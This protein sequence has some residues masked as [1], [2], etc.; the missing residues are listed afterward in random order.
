MASTSPRFGVGP[1]QDQTGRVIKFDFKTPAYGA[2]IAVHPNAS[3][4]IVKVAQLTGAATITASTVDAYAGDELIFLFAADGTGR[5]VTFG[6]GLKP[7]A[8]L[9]VTA[10]KFGSASFMFDGT[11]WIETGRAITA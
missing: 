2:T 5:T 7:S 1:N 4:T 6:T 8:T 11:N 9:A 10:S 3:K